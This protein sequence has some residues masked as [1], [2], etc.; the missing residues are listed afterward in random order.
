MK[1]LWY[2]RDIGKAVALQVGK[3]FSRNA[4]FSFFSPFHYGDI[5][6][7]SIPNQRWLKVKNK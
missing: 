6:E 7:P 4:A 1:A 3:V 5:E 2:D